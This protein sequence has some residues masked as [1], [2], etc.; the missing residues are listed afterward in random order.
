M[1]DL[2]LSAEF[3]EIEWQPHPTLVGIE[4]KLLQ[5]KGGFSP[6]DVMVA[7]V[8]PSSEIPWHVHAAESE[9]AFVIQGTGILYTA[10]NE[11]R[12]AF[13]ATP[14]AVGNAIVVPPR[15]WHCVKNVGSGDLMLFAS[16]T[17]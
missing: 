12:E 13:S 9:I 10:V 16:H 5:N 8:A 17:S 2:P 3:D 14:L 15:L 4:V 7:R 6:K 1:V 11:A